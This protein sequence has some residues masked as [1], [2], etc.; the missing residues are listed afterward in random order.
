MGGVWRCLEGVWKESGRC[1]EGVWK[2][3]WR[4][5]DSV[6]NVSGKYLEDVWKVSGRYLEDV[7]RVPKACPYLLT[8]RNICQLNIYPHWGRIYVHHIILIKES[9]E[10]KETNS[11]IVAT[12]GLHLGFSAKG[13]IW[14]VPTCKMEPRSS[15][16][17]QLGPPT[18]PPH[19][20]KIGSLQDWS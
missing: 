3:S 10:T 9:K 17:M 4:C 2:M 5:L 7:W 12:L 19:Q 18:H 14:R 15:Y 20:L 8:I 11:L 13:R 1:L 6:W 16:I